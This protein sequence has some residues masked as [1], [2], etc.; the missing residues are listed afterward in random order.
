MGNEHLVGLGELLLQGDGVLEE[1]Q[2]LGVVHLQQHAGQLAS[3]LREARVH[4][5]VDVI[6]ENLLL[7]LRLGRGKER[8]KLLGS[9]LDCLLCKFV[10]GNN[11]NRH[12]SDDTYSGGG[13]T[14]LLLHIACLRAVALVGA[15]CS[16]GNAS[17][18]SL[19]GACSSEVGAWLTSAAEVA[20]KWWVSDG[21]I[22]TTLRASLRALAVVGLLGALG[23]EWS[24]NEHGWEYTGLWGHESL[25]LALVL[26]ALTV[27][28][29]ELLTTL[30]TGLHDNIETRDNKVG[31]YE[32][33]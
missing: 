4:Q 27:L 14:H 22:A 29:G 13:Q 15:R 6:P 8:S 33:T 3:N 5:R 11:N 2:Q 26:H 16:L 18:T 9:I 7:A 12:Q 25:L 32:Y 28:H 24:A 19:A 21:S 1:M 17:A 31:K 23:S 20:A 30:L 10:S